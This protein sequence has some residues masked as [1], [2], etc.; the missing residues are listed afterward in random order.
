[1]T[2]S[3]GPS[4]WECARSSENE[5]ARERTERGERS[6]RSLLRF[7]QGIS[8]RVRGGK[9]ATLIQIP[10]GTVWCRMPLNGASG[11]FSEGVSSVAWGK[12]SELDCRNYRTHAY[13]SARH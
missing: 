12:R 11:P 5:G 13:G 7:L 9:L 2:V 1:M 10:C 6:S 4:T 8:S 3:A